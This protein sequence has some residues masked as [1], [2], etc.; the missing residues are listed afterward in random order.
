MRRAPLCSEWQLH[1]FPEIP[2]PRVSVDNRKLIRSVSA[3]LSTGII[4]GYMDVSG[5]E[6]SSGPSFISSKIM[7]PLFSTHLI[8]RHPPIRAGV[9]YSQVANILRIEVRALLVINEK[10]TYECCS[11][12]LW[13]QTWKVLAYSKLR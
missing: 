7:I 4:I 8:L 6:A 5:S 2:W 13:R 3:R 1:I 10:C 9:N 12:N 11:L